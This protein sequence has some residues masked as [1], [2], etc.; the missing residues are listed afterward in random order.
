M[1]HLWQRIFAYT[2]ILLIL[3]QAAVLLLHRY[4]LNS[5]E[6][7]RFV[8]Q[9]AT[10]LAHAL[11]GQRLSTAEAILPLFSRRDNKAWLE[12]SDGL[13]L[14]G[15][16]PPGWRSALLDA[17]DHWE[18]D[19]LK[20]WALKSD[21]GRFVVST[22]LALRNSDVSLMMTFGPPRR[23]G[24]W[25]MFFQGLVVLSV[26]GVLM[27]LWM[28]WHVSRPLR[29]LRGEVMAI[30][31]DHLDRRVTVKGKDEIADVAVAVNHLA[32]SLSRNI[33]S[34]RELV[35]NVSHELRSP[36]ARMQVSLALL[37]ENLPPKG[38]ADKNAE[39]AVAKAALLRE[40]LDHMDRLISATLLTSKLD[41]EDGRPLAPVAFSDLC[42]EM[43]RRHA[44]IM[45]KRG[46]AFSPIIEAGVNLIGDETLLCTLVSN[47]LDNAAK[48]ADE[49]GR[50]EARLAREQD[51]VLLAVE[52]THA[53]LPEDM[54]ERI[55]EPF[56]RAGIATGNGV[57]LGL[58]LVRKIAARHKAR[59]WAENTEN[60]VRFRVSFPA[61]PEAG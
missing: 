13:T 6:I 40:E 53:P 12:N 41:L 4:S 51:K 54:L 28:A 44:P 15:S 32:D 59:A 23:P 26:V 29:R 57:G 35:A 14:A 47:L 1:K 16:P 33:L 38:K 49:H 18:V 20:I 42:A 37:E 31:E 10:E 45:D 21:D 50:V 5:E 36:L 17:R 22:P 52:N 7:R 46:L 48:Y 56:N 34:M 43:C 2:L 27:A 55:F 9:S 60:G 39:R 11:E 30:A 8:S 61:A 24:F 58:S 3:S 25:G 19:S